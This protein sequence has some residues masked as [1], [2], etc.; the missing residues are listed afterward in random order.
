MGGYE[1]GLK[2]LAKYLASK[3]TTIV[4]LGKSAAH[5]EDDLAR[6]GSHPN[7]IR[8]PQRQILTDYVDML[9]RIQQANT[10][11]E[12]MVVEDHSRTNGKIRFIAERLPSV[13]VV[14]VVGKTSVTNLSNCRVLEIDPIQ[15]EELHAARSTFR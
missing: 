8:S 2:Y 13:E 3:E 12:I 7:I 9:K 5:I 11:Q 4:L 10:D 1:S 14:S 15:A 6:L